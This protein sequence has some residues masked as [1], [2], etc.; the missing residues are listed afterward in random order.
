MNVQEAQSAVAKL[1][2]SLDFDVLDVL[3]AKLANAEQVLGER[4][5]ELAKVNAAVEAESKNLSRITQAARDV[6][7]EVAEKKLKL[8]KI[9]AQL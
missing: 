1:K 8:Q 3:L 5:A 9:L 6:D 4:E 2:A 7:A